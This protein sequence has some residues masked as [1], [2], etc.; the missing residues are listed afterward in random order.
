MP[1]KNIKR[2][3][4]PT[5]KMNKKLRLDC[6]QIVKALR[7]EKDLPQNESRLVAQ[8]V[9]HSLGV[10]SDERHEF[11][12]KAVEM[13]GDTLDRIVRKL[14]AAAEEATAKVSG[15]DAEK[16][17]REKAVID[18]SNK[19][20]ATKGEAAMK[21]AAVFQAD[22][23]LKQAK[24]EFAACQ[25]TLPVP[26]REHKDAITKRSELEQ[27]LTQRVLPLK[28][29]CATSKS[30]QELVKLLRKFGVDES[31]L[32]VLPSILSK[33][34]GERGDFG[35]VSMVNLENA[36]T[37]KLQEL[38]ADVETIAPRVATCNAAVEVAQAAFDVAKNE[39]QKSKEALKE[40]EDAIRTAE[41]ELQRATRS[42][43]NLERDMKETEASSMQH[44]K[45]LAAFYA[46]PMKAFTSLKSLTAP[47]PPVV[48]P[49]PGAAENPP[50]AGETVA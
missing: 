20:A 6:D 19:L 29:V 35:T 30:I 34:P 10:Y 39:L 24:Q 21:E 40:V 50:P 3:A 45:R 13:V 33:D 31:L 9:P 44:E 36:L 49:V 43:D 5:A 12:A 47:P 15:R 11:Q 32:S 46:G 22:L 1:S 4:T 23:K 41:A 28:V 26:M 18:H 16:A 25:K 48:E 7:E 17:A 14:K 27:V 42:N 2:S 38:T 8:L 37:A